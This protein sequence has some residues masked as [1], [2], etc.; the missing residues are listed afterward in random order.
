MTNKKKKWTFKVSQDLDPKSATQ[1][2][3]LAEKY[4]ESHQTT[5]STVQGSTTIVKL[6]VE[7]KIPRDN[8][9]PEL[10]EV[11]ANLICESGEGKCKD[12]A[13]A[14]K[15]LNKVKRQIFLLI[16][17]FKEFYSANQNTM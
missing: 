16:C 5:T 1:N 15:E 10:H 11:I 3:F 13:I 4:F 17:F 2:L 6:W 14:T 12:F 9:F 7:F 8:T